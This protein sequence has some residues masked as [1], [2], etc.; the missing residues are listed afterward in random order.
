M[1]PWS[2]STAV[3]AKTPTDC[4]R[5]RNTDKGLR[6]N[7]DVLISATGSSFVER[8][9]DTYESGIRRRD[10]VQVQFLF[11]PLGSAQ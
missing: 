8:D 7:E 2:F 6:G 5:Y 4:K 3:S 11:A 9:L 10:E 1:S